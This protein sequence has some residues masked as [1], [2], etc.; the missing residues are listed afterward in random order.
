MQEPQAPATHRPYTLIAELT[1]RCPL[2]CVYCSNPVQYATDKKPELDTAAWQQAF[3]DA[4]A[5]GVV[6][7]N[8]TGGE[9][10]LRDDLETLI[11]HA[12]RIGLYMSLISSAVGLTRERLQ[13]LQQCGLDHV[14]ISVQGVTDADA[15]R[16]A[17]R[18]S[19]AHKLE[20]ARWVR[21][22]GLPL[23]LNVVL[24]RENIEQVPALIEL[25]VNVGADRLE[26]ANTQYLGW[27]LLNRDALLPSAAQI[28]RA[29]A[30]ADAARERLLGKL[31]LLFVLPDYQAGVARP[32]MQGW[33]R[34]YILISPDGLVLPCHQAHTLPGLEWER[35]GDRPLRE[36][37]N[38]S[39]GLNAFRGEAWMAE[40]C[41]SC[42]RRTIDF[43]GCRCQAFHLTGQLHVTDPAC[44]LSPEHALVTEARQ[45]AENVKLVEL[46]YRRVPRSL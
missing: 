9:P 18:S 22:L 2:R 23:T 46:R 6:Q 42:E 32:C 17:G 31:E 27:A 45:A 11:E 25:A 41:R 19:L 35:V 14:Q 20:C 3:S 12:H 29:R 30:Q 43:G 39:T 5:L 36:I 28:D 40:P 1:Y 38:H 13:A 24:H 21:E 10:L 4:E 16:I 26:L 15:V 33:A 8:L 34:R 44:P 37:W 7:L